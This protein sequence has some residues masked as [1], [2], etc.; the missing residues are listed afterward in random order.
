MRSDCGFEFGEVLTSG[1]EFETGLDRR[2]RYW[3][4]DPVSVRYLLRSL[5]IFVARGTISTIAEVCRQQRQ[6]DFSSL[7]ETTVPS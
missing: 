1:L 6:N 2:L 5:D 3:A 4:V 7:N